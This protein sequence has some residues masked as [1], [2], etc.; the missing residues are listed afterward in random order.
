MITYCNLKRKFAE[1]AEYDQ[2]QILKSVVRKNLA[3]WDA[4]LKNNAS[5]IVAPANFG[6]TTEI[7]H[8]AAR[9]RDTSQH[10][11]FLSLRRFIETRS[12]AASLVGD[13]LTSLAEW[14]N[15]N[16]SE[17]VLLV[18]SLDEASAGKSRNIDYCLRQIMEDFG[19]LKA[20]VKW[21][22]STRP[23]VLTEEL[24]N[25]IQTLLVSPRKTM[26]KTVEGGGEQASD[27]EVSEEK[28]IEQKLH[29]YSM[30]E[31]NE[32]Q[33]LQYLESKT[34]IKEARQ[35]LDIA[36]ERGL[37]GYT[38][39]PGGLDILANIDLIANPPNS[40]T[41]VYSRVT[42]AIGSLRAIDERFEDVGNPAQE[43]LI[44]GARKLASASQICQILNIGIQTSALTI[45]PTSIS[46][47]LIANPMLS[48][49]QLRTLLSTQ[50]FVD[51]KFDEVKMY[52]N[53]LPPYLGAQRLNKL[54]QTSEQAI[55]LI[56]NFTWR[57][58]TG[59]SGVYPQFLPLMGWL[60]TMNPHCRIEL[61]KR[62]PQAL[63]F[64]GDMRNPVVPADIA[65][66]SLEESIKRLVDS[67][68]RLGRNHFNLTHENFW[69][70]GG[71][72][73]EPTILKL[74]TNY[75]THYWARDALLDIVT[76][77]RTPVLRNAVLTEHQNSY[78]NLIKNSADL[79]YILQLR[80]HVDLS[81][82][83]KAVRISNALTESAATQIVR[84]LRWTYLSPKDIN[85]I[86]NS[87]Y[88]RDIETT[89]IRYLLA[90]EGI[91]DEADDETLEAF[92]RE[93]IARVIV[94]PRSSE[95]EESYSASK[96]IEFTSIVLSK[97]VHRTKS[98]DVNRV[99]RLC[100]RMNLILHKIYFN[101]VDSSEIRKAL[102]EN[103]DVRIAL[104][105]KIIAKP[106]ENEW[107]LNALLGF[108][109]ICDYRQS[110]VD[111]INVPELSD[112]YA[113]VKANIPAVSTQSVGVA[114]SNKKKEI[115]RGIDKKTK[116]K[117][118]ANLAKIASAKDESALVFVA[119]WLLQT[120][121][122]SR[123]GE[124]DFARF[125]ELV[126]V[127]VADAV[128]SGFAK[129]WRTVKPRF[130][131][132]EQNSTYYITVAAL[133]GL[134]IELSDGTAMP[135]LS[136]SE[137]EAALL[138]ATFEMN[139]YPKWF[140][141]LVRKYPE[142]A[143][144][145]LIQIAKGYTKGKVSMSHAESLLSS[146][147]DAPDFVQQSLHPIAWNY[148]VSS[149]ATAEYIGKSIFE[150][151]MVQP[152]YVPKTKLAELALG[153]IHEAYASIE[154]SP[155]S[156]NPKQQEA[157]MWG[158]HWFLNDPTGFTDAIDGWGERN[159]DNGRYFVTH[160][161][162]YFGRD[163]H[164]RLYSLSSTN[165][166]LD[167]LGRFHDWAVWAVNPLDD[168]HRPSGKV[169]SPG[170]R[171]DAES[172]RD[173]L[174]TI[175][176]STYSERAYQILGD[177]RRHETGLREMYIR[178]LQFELREK[179]AFRES[180]KQ[181]QYD[182]FE[183]DLRGDVT[184][185]MAFSYS[186][187]SDL[188][189]I[190]YEIERGE[191]SLRGF[192]N[193][194]QFQRLNAKGREGEKASLALEA[195]FQILLASELRHLSQNSYDVSMEPQTAENNR[196]DIKC[197][198]NGWHASIELKMTERWTLDDYLEALE[199]QLVGQYMRN[200]SASTGF[201]V[202]V[203]Q[204]ERKWGHGQ[205]ALNF[206]QIVEILQERA[207]HLEAKQSGLYLRVVG[208]DATVPKSFR[209]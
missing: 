112:A 82:I 77:S 114:S 54:V 38:K 145:T 207:R 133:Q 203:Q 163:R 74:F 93:L 165:D 186:V 202:L 137:I 29:L 126:P 189:Y 7:S 131:E 37:Y 45:S 148:L 103:D 143:T 190:K 3:D 162:A 101:Y 180:I 51:A 200:H 197:S 152:E 46:A 65:A 109:S 158:A 172:L 12:L 161:A 127:K 204:R 141:P 85:I 178:R 176:Q 88:Q 125:A 208:I 149:G 164:K 40:L 121:S 63:A 19:E 170:V 142:Q 95:S 182:E 139:G 20:R 108:L 35:L 71:E 32:K 113:F 111:I 73:M 92:T 48:E 147:Q 66:S 135:R 201:L 146:L 89:S 5:V 110:D 86:I 31:L 144:A 43:D 171:D 64:F 11:V 9:L 33:G 184:D 150:A 151:M 168:I 10:A 105:R 128:Q 56:E 68:D 195:D 117:L 154:G 167:A 23:A 156:R 209:D 1:L 97:L 25:S 118:A 94:R 153:K 50:L 2:E 104:L 28:T 196:R 76:A 122:N 138:Y 30:L 58:S 159:I 39:S 21:I 44:E 67:G 42:L 27:G 34:S 155:L 70:A 166:G 194:V 181:I 193:K 96:M 100:F 90:D 62:D 124:V 78:E 129:L 52:P 119:H 69:Q 136:N 140:W 198:K 22:I 130:N 183:K 120:N 75:G 17:L 205:S 173:S 53:E 41:E 49:G 57:A 169:F 185:S 18:D 83:V 102:N 80:N 91:L 132:D 160:L 59:E 60:A 81:G 72:R 188:N 13:C 47:K 206:L 199:K 26:S 174:P 107:E 79:H 8:L 187:E 36:Y 116:T 175:I 14:K 192:F 24:F 61:V 177:I 84:A 99:A 98:D 191:F 134:Y 123:Y 4:V 55:R 16:A 15:D 115:R 179:Q 106:K 87:L 6:K 157:V